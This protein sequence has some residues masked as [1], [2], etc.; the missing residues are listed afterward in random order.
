MTWRTYC[1]NL[2]THQI[3]MYTESENYFNSYKTFVQNQYK[4]V[5]DYYNYENW[6]AGSETIPG[7]PP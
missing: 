6:P 1:L 4:I 7:S 2:Q 5:I 3:S